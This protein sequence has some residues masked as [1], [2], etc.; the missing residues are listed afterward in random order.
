MDKVDRAILTCLKNNAR[1]KASDI[2]K[3]INLSVSAVIER[4]KKL[5][6][7]GTIEKYT[8]CLNQKQIGNDVVAIIEIKLEH[9]KYYDAFTTTIT[10]ENSVQECLY[11]T[12]EFDFMLKVVAGSSENLEEIHRKIKKISGVQSTK[13]YFVLKTIKNEMS[14]IPE[15]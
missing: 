11:L 7:N 5:E 2:G 15:N 9:P 10:R 1:M 12:G 3:A 8:V 13:T 4:I 14:I 6:A